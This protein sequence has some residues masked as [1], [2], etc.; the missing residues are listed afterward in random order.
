[1]VDNSDL[2]KTKANKFQYPRFLE[3]STEF[4]KILQCIVSL[5][6]NKCAAY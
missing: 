6:L 2:K 4:P 1:M 5:R 3:I